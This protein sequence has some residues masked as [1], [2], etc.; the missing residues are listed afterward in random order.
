MSITPEIKEYLDVLRWPHNRKH[1]TAL[2]WTPLGKRKPG[3][4][5]FTWR[6]TVT[7]KLET[8]GYTYLGSSP[9]HGYGQREV[10]EF[11]L[12]LCPTEIK[13]IIK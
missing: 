13:W 1:K 7:A 10:G 11:V 3:R 6:R 9:V 5:R 8:F 2:Y 12:A 4:H